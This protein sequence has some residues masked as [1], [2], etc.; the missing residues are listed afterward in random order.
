MKTIHKLIVC[1]LLFATYQTSQAQ[2][3]YGRYGRGY[4]ANYP[5]T[6]NKSNEL[7]EKEKEKRVEESVEKLK[8]SLEL[9]DLQTFA[10]KNDLT[11]HAKNV[12]K[13]IKNES[14]SNEDK[15]KEIQN[16]NDKLEKSILSY[17]NP[18]Q[19]EKYNILKEELTSEKKSEKKKKKK[20]D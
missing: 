11:A 16:L 12:E 14:I 9:D 6:P 1:F 7:S 3:G 5:T 10:V 2:Y 19:K 13:V 8:T 4:G 17:L 18:K 15:S 20:E